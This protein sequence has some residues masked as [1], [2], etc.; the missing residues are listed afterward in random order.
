[1][2]KLPKEL[3][4]EMDKIVNIFKRAETDECTSVKLIL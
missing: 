1:M 4:I 2:D 3:Q